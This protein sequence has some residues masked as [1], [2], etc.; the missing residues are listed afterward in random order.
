MV[1]E[2][3]KESLN[4]ILKLRQY[5]EKLAHLEVKKWIGEMK[6]V[7]EEI[8]IVQCEIKEIE[9]KIGNQLKEFSDKLKGKTK[10]FDFVLL[11]EYIKSLKNDHR[12]KKGLETNLKGDLDKICKNLKIAKERLAE[13]VAERKAIEMLIEKRIQEERRAKEKKEE[14]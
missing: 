4:S 9:K 5:D 10:V 14:E 6:R 3:R 2:K 12:K 7:E 13:K 11:S 1:K 8:E